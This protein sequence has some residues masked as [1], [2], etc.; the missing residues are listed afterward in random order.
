MRTV[1]AATLGFGKAPSASTTD[2]YLAGTVNSVS[3][4]SLHRRGRELGA[5]QRRAAQWGGV[6]R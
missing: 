2:V 3:G 1:S 5:D 6:S 4:L